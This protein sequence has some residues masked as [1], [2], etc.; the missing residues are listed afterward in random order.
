MTLCPTWLLNLETWDSTFSVL[1][2]IAAVTLH[3]VGSTPKYLQTHLLPITSS[4]GHGAPDLPSSPPGG[5]S[6]ILTHPR[7]L[8]SAYLIGFLLVIGVIFFNLKSH[9]RSISTTS[10]PNPHV[11]I[12][13]IIII[14]LAVPLP[15]E[16]SQAR[17]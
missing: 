15:C 3:P 7:F 12:I 4:G 1:P 6:C 5:C 2:G 10:T 11:L 13:I 14:I 8:C 9:Y 16:S 17:D